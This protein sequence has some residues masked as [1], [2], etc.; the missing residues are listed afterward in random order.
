MR[1]IFLITCALILAGCSGPI[2][3]LVGSRV[4]IYSTP[5]AGAM[6]ACAALADVATPGISPLA[7]V[8]LA[9]GAMSA[10]NALGDTPADAMEKCAKML[11]AVAAD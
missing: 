2:S 5:E 10:S 11:R 9:R 6:R 7:I 4:T 3:S 1:L 8:E